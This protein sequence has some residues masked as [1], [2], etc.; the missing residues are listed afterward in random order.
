MHLAA[1]E[2]IIPIKGSHAN[3]KRS[4]KSLPKLQLNPRVIRFKAGN[5]PSTMHLLLKKK[6]WRSI[7]MFL[8][9]R[10]WHSCLIHSL[11]SKTKSGKR[12]D[13]QLE[14]HWATGDVCCPI[15]VLQN[16]Q[17]HP[18]HFAEIFVIHSIY[19]SPNPYRRRMA[20]K[21]FFKKLSIDSSSINKIS[22]HIK[23]SHNKKKLELQPTL[24]C[25]WTYQIVENLTLFIFTI[26][27]LN[28]VTQDSGYFFTSRNIS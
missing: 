28:S 23:H 5:Q 12:H 24:K 17:K 3:Y 1:T 4:C 8:S 13:R 19:V 20:Y 10:C 9:S 16:Q 7:P 26:S 21:F 15:T 22:L 25:K 2:W 27:I 14:D 11:S 6:E 18:F